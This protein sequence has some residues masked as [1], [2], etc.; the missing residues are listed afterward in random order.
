M[1]GGEKGP[2]G[3]LGPVPASDGT[4]SPGPEV[5]DPKHSAGGCL[6]KV[7]RRNENHVETLK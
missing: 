4:A 2:G 6:T 7:P 5:P 3:G 1:L